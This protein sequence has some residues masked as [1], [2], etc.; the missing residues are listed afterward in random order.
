VIPHLYDVAQF[1]RRLLEKEVD[2]GRG[3]GI[4]PLAVFPRAWLFRAQTADRDRRRTVAERESMKN[5]ITIS[6]LALAASVGSAFAGV[7][8]NG[9]SS[10]GGWNSAATGQTNGVWVLGSTNR[11]FDIYRSV[12]VLSASQTVGGTRL[13]DGAVG[14]GTSYSGD[15]ASSLFSNSWQAGDRIVGIGIAYSGSTRGDT[16]FFH[17]DSGAANI[18]AASSVGA[19][20]GILSF[21]AGDTSSYVLS[22]Y[23]DSRRAKVWQYS[24][25]NAFSANGGSNFIAPYGLTPS[26]AMPTRSFAI[27][28]AGSTSAVK[29]I[30]FFLNVDAVLRGNGGLGYGEG[31]LLAASTR[32]GFFEAGTDGYTEQIF[33]VPTPGAAA[34]LG[35]GGL[36]AARRRR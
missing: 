13:A 24:I 17:T 14:N 8:I 6:A 28:D 19:G 21:D 34:L 32:I 11:T 5:L 33:S 35:L 25:F 4:F 1:L 30:Q 36:L 23:N 27:M 20:D 7:D 22:T 16:F 9:G 15:T 10:W 12:F 3:E 26:P 2:K 31:D 18:V 29:S